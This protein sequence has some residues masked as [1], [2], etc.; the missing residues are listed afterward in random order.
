MEWNKQEVQEA[1]ISRLIHG[2]PTTMYNIGVGPKSEYLTLKTIYPNMNIFGCEPLASEYKGLRKRFNGKLHEVAIGEK[3][4]KAEIS[5]HR[6]AMMGASIL[7]P[8]E[9]ADCTKTVKVITLDEFDELC[10][11]PDRI[12]LWADIEGMELSMLKSGPKLLDS[13]RVRW[14]NL[15]E[16]IDD[17][18]DRENIQ[19]LLEKF[20]FRRIMTYNKHQKHNDV[21]YVHNGEQGRK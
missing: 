21:V 13:G 17:T 3:T 10:G 16:H 9:A 2:A 8:V 4:G 14:I 12:L 20:A 19:Y 18:G 5:Y 1:F 7:R 11:K 6:D 15:E